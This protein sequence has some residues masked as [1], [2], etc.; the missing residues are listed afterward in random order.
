MPLPRS[1]S[2]ETPSTGS[3]SSGGSNGAMAAVLVIALLA[4]AIVA[5]FSVN[6]YRRRRN[7]ERDESM[8]SMLF[9][10]SSYRDRPED[11]INIAPRRSSNYDDVYL[12]SLALSSTDP[13][14]TVLA[15]SKPEVLDEEEDD[16]P[17]VYIGPPRDEDGHELHQV[18]LV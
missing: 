3:D 1:G 11:A 15:P 5:V 17:Q 14:A 16:Q 2:E 4:M 7:K 13:M 8:T 6:L 18:D 9:W 12:A 10:S